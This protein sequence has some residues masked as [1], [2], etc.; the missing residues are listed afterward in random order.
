MRLS[1]KV[2]KQGEVLKE[3][4]MGGQL[5]PA[6]SSSSSSP[7]DSDSKRVSP[8]PP[9]L[10]GIPGHAFEPFFLL[11]HVLPFVHGVV[12]LLPRHILER[13]DPLWVAAHESKP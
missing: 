12:G 4:R 1:K 13:G 11:S 6:S 5:S 7:K 10:Y 2:T 8:P 9:Y 3:R